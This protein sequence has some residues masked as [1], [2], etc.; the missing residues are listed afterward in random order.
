MNRDRKAIKIKETIP[1]MA[2]TGVKNFSAE[3]PSIPL[4]SATIQKKG[5]FTWD[6]II[7]PAPTARTA[8]TG[9]IPS[10]PARGEITDAAVIIEIVEEPVAVLKM[11]AIINGRNIPIF[12]VLRAIMRE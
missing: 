11:A 8:S 10:E 9:S 12:H 4:N 1:V 3:P 6:T 2:V 7:D 5:S